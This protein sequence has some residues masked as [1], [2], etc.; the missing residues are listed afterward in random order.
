MMRNIFAGSI[1]VLTLLILGI[2]FSPAAPDDG[3]SGEKEKPA[4]AVGTMLDRVMAVQNDPRLQ[5]RQHKN[6]RRRAIKSII[7]GNFHFD[8]MSR[9]VLGNY[10][11]QL[12]DPERAAFQAVF[13]DLFLDS[14]TK[15]VLD[16]LKREKIVY[17]Q[18]DARQEE[19]LVKTKIVRR[20]EEIPVDYSLALVRERWLVQDVTIDGVSI[21][22]NY[23]RSFTRVIRQGSFQVLLDKMRIQQQ[24]VE[25]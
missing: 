1:A 15:L 17:G 18:V 2:T 10:A 5:D 23:R 3:R 22:D 11:G 24:A 25:K 19:A 21:M 7:A 6:E 8:G 20:N 13:Q 12:G 14:Y 9:L 16:F 4:A